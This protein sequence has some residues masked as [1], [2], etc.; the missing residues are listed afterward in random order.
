MSKFLGFAVF[1]GIIYLAY[2]FI[3]PS[4]KVVNN[5]Q[6]NNIFANVDFEKLLPSTRPDDSAATTAPKVNSPAQT[7]KTNPPPTPTPSNITRA[8]PEVKNNPLEI[9]YVR[10]DV[11]NIGQIIA[12]DTTAGLLA[13]M[14][15]ESQNSIKLLEL[16]AQIEALYPKPDKG[17]VKLARALNQQ[18]LAAFAQENYA[19]AASLFLDAARANPADIEALNNYAYAL[20]KDGNYQNS[21]QV[22]G[23]VLSLAP[24]RT[25]AW[26][27]LGEIYANTNRID[28]SAASFVI[29]FQFSGNKEKTL[30]FFNQTINSTNSDALK[31]AITK[32]LNQLSNS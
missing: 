3:V 24:G 6:Q 28:A 20:L 2:H 22:L 26:A 8:A 16:K 29:A 31:S 27:N 21:Q 10:I 25:S 32:A 13:Q 12:P 17:D 4:N 11:R 7:L 30:D 18:G 14:L 1:I 19:N 5:D 15:T 9:K 23:Y